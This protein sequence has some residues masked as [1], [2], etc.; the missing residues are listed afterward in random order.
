MSVMAIS[1]EEPQIDQDIRP[2]GFEAVSRTVFRDKIPTFAYMA[3]GRDQTSVT[4]VYAEP[5]RQTPA[6]E[7]S[8]PHWIAK[9]VSQRRGED[10][11]VSW[12]DSRTCPNLQGVLWS[13]S[14]LPAPSLTILGIDPVRP[15]SGTLT[16][17][18]PT[19][20]AV[21]TVWGVA[22]DAL[23]P[24]LQ[25]EMRAAWGPLSDWGGSAELSLEECWTDEEPALPPDVPPYTA[26]SADIS[27]VGQRRSNDSEEF[28][29]QPGD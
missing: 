15:P 8:A 3:E 2:D 11:R 19:H 14:T 21:Y 10:P 4:Y 7:R 6:A 23:Q 24:H 12:A 29:A 9:R 27:E 13:A 26:P 16:T 25:V 18:M 28:P 22:R 17:P 1:V 20:G 5:F